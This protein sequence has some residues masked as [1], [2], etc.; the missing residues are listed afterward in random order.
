MVLLMNMKQILRLICWYPPA[1][2]LLYTHFGNHLQS[3]GVPPQGDADPCTAL[4]VL[5]NP[6]NLAVDAIDFPDELF[7]AKISARQTQADIIH[8]KNADNRCAEKTHP[9][10][11]L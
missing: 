10:S 9:L 8:R 5:D 1:S 2:V 3:V 11:R 7:L 4:V 6:S